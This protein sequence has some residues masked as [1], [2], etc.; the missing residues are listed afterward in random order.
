MTFIIYPHP[1]LFPQISVVGYGVRLSRIDPQR[2]NFI[3]G[4]QSITEENREV[5]TKISLFLGVGICS[6][7]KRKLD[8]GS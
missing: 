3:R 6:E 1:Q 2:P 4:N 7:G 8:L 5:E